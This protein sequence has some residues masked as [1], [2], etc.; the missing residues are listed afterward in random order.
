MTST[1]PINRPGHREC[2][3]EYR[4]TEYLARYSNFLRVRILLDAHRDA[5][6]TFIFSAQLA[7]DQIFRRSKLRYYRSRNDNNRE[8]RNRSLETD[9]RANDISLIRNSRAAAS[10]DD[11]ERTSE[12]SLERCRHVSNIRR[13]GIFGL[14][15]ETFSEKTEGCTEC[16]V[17][18]LF[19]PPRSIDFTSQQRRTGCVYCENIKGTIRACVDKSAYTP[20]ELIGPVTDGR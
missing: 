6:D 12:R 7:C 3:N 20:R 8:S 9:G 16:T 4:I 18:P 17:P 19:S 2:S 13:N 11:D 5:P 15:M 10:D 14:E 1:I